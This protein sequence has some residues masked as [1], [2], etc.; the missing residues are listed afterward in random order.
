[1]IGGEATDGD[2]PVE[3]VLRSAWRASG[4]NERALFERLAG[5]QHAVVVEIAVDRR[6]DHSA[7]GERPA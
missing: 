4:G 6:V 3:S 5:I 7:L 2:G 1:M